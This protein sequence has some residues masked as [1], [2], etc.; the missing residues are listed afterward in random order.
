MEAVLNL[1]GVGG[2][3]NS[4][5]NSP[6]LLPFVD[7]SLVKS[8]EAIIE[9]EIMAYSFQTETTIA[10]WHYKS[11]QKYLDA[12]K[13]VGLLMQNVSRNG[14]ML[15]NLTQHGRGDLDPE[16][17]RIC[18]D[19]GAWLKVNGEAVYASRPFEVAGDNSVSY[20]RN[21]G[22]VYA[23]LLDWTGGP[24]TLKALRAGGAT[25]GKVSK[26]ELVGSD[27]ALTFV[28][29][30]QGLLVTPSGSAQPLPGI[31]D[32]SLATA[33]RVLRITHDKGW[34]N[35]DDPGVVAPGWMR[36]SN[37]GAGEYNNDLTISETPG[38]VWSASFTGSSVSVIAPKEAGAGKIEVQI[39]GRTRATADEAT[40][41]PRL[42]QQPVCEVTGL[43]PGKHSINIINRG[44]GPV[45]VDALV[46]Q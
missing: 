23:T 45:A 35:D 22:K 25:L 43:A 19:V 24:V 11:G 31:T 41:G 42:T 15:L 4:F 44:S 38:N 21:E 5:Q 40:S 27:M 26:V 9:P 39:D 29:N 3:Y 12:K 13:L 1:K 32:Q 16:V 34:I 14:T 10:D 46:V 28:Q 20:T 33:I 7:H 8:T 37:L 30:D 17:I 36:R 2:R 6:E 18:K